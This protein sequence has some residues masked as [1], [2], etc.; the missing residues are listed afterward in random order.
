MTFT[1]DT[2]TLGG[3]QYQVAPF[4]M[5]GDFRDIQLHWTQAGASQDAEFHY[6]E[7]HYTM[8]GV[9]KEIV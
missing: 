5:N 7:A 3:E 6:L 1:L 9:S 8:G 2:S 4:D